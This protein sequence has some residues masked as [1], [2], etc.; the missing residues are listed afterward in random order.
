MEYKKFYLAIRRYAKDKITRG[1]FLVEWVDAQRSQGMDTKK[2]KR[3]AA[4]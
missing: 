3:A 4:P 1:D 2:L